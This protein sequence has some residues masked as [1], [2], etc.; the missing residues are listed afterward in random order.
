MH[1]YAIKLASFALQ[2][3]HSRAT[4]PSS[5]AGIAVLTQVAKT[6]FPEIGIILDTVGGGSALGAIFKAEKGVS[7]ENPDPGSNLPRVE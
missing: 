6:Y 4:E 5:L 1:H 7:I 3:A 2:I